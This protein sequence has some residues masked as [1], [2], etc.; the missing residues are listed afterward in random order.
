M[1][2]RSRV[3]DGAKWDL[4]MVPRADYQPLGYVITH[5]PDA[6]YP[7]DMAQVLRI[8]DL[9]DPGFIPIFRRMTYRTQAGAI[10]TF[11]HHGVARAGRLVTPDMMIV[12]APKPT[13]WK[14]GTATFV[15]RWFE[16]QVIKG[17]VRAKNNLPP[18]FIPWG[19]WVEA[20]CRE[21]YWAAS[22]REKML[23]ADQYGSEVQR[24]KAR[25]AEEAE[26]AY[27]A[28]HDLA[29][30]RRI[31]ESLGADDVRETIA[32]Q[33]GQIPHEKKP[34]VHLQGAGV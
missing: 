29:Y 25:E 34:F 13:G 15:E 30:Q 1:S 5:V 28:K 3:S 27:R 11:I 7:Y 23:Y 12:K 17:S 18:P 10:L 9:Y 8:R 32:R 26:T 19:G 14:F 16:G 22:A 20:W 31:F 6:I 33:N 4:D 24:R 21:T 2:Y